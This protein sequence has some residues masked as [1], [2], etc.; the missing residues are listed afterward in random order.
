MVA[1]S[2]SKRPRTLLASTEEPPPQADQNRKL[3]YIAESF[4]L[5]KIWVNTRRVQMDECWC[6]EYGFV[7]LFMSCI[8]GAR[9]LPKAKKCPFEYCHGERQDKAIPTI[10][11]SFFK[12]LVN[13]ILWGH[14][15]HIRRCCCKDLTTMRENK[16]KEKW[17]GR[18]GKTARVSRLTRKP[19]YIGRFH[20][21]RPI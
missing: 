4:I 3:I 2:S 1:K 13:Y 8:V 21:S 5:T 7:V 10:F 11:G 19:A 14:D 12:H 15:V 18:F 16:S 9:S 20:V 17:G 6:P